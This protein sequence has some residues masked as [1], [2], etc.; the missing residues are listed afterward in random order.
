MKEEGEKQSICET[1]LLRRELAELEKR[2]A[3]LRRE[4]AELEKREHYLSDVVRTFDKV[5]VAIA[6]ANRRGEPRRVYCVID[7]KDNYL[8]TKICTVCGKD[9]EECE[10]YGSFVYKE[11]DDVIDEL[12]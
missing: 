8:A 12:N 1:R 9:Y 10:H 4:L 11:L 3:E 5:N 6:E 7:G 2:E